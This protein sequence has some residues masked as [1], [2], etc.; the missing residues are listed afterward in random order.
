MHLEYWGLSKA[1][2]GSKLTLS[3]FFESSTHVE[4]LARLQYLVQQNRRLGVL[5]GPSGTGKSLT[6]EVLA[7]RLRRAGAYVGKLNLLGLDA[8]EFLWGL[9]SA[10]GCHV[11]ED[12]NTITV[13]RTIQ[14]R[15]ATLR[16][17]RIPTVLLLDDADECETA[18]LT[19]LCRVAQMEQLPESQ[20]SIVLSC[21]RNG[22]QLLGER[23]LE[24]SE[25]P[26]E[27]EPFG[28][29]ETADYI[30]IGL[31]RVGRMDKTFTDDA[32]DTI[33]RFTRGV[34]RAINQLAELCLVGGAAEGLK[35]IDGS[36][37]E[38]VREAFYSEGLGAV[39]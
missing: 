28:E 8:P 12:A 29:A 27:L 22:K 9:A 25:L 16:Y 32:H 37:V 35:L 18:V 26:V 23:L 2:F 13:W 14:D 10:L 17:Q 1:P 34:P 24:L 19:T 4:A 20:L 6:L 30:S 3:E 38:A 33:C 5:L 15:L 39:A 21:N 31:A 36:F 7:R 11:Y